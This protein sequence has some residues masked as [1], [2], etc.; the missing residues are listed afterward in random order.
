LQSL[1]RLAMM[2]GWMMWGGVLV[3]IAIV[4]YVPLSRLAVRRFHRSMAGRPWLTRH[5]VFY[6]SMLAVLYTP[7]C[8]ELDLRHGNSLPVPLPAWLALAAGSIWGGLLPLCIGWWIAHSHTRSRITP[9]WALEPSQS[10]EGDSE[11]SEVE[12]PK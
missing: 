11:G 3:L 4:A 12:R 5:H 6:A 9:E 1:E 2:I 10:H 8:L 7:G